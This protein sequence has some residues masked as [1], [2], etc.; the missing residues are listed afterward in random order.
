MT[1]KLPSLGTAGCCHWE[2]FLH[3]L[4]GG[5][6]GVNPQKACCGLGPQPGA[7]TR[8]PAQTHAGPKATRSVWKVSDSSDGGRDE[9]GEEGASPDT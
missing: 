3:P 8:P 7:A 2:T 1:P 5:L 4:G 9:D 6:T